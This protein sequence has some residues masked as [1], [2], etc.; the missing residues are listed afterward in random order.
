MRRHARQIRR[1]GMQPLM[2]INSGDDLPEPASLVLARWLGQYRSEL[3]PLPVAGAVLGAA[4]WLHTTHARW[5]GLVLAV[6]VTAAIVIAV[7]GPKLGLPDP[8]ERLYGAATVLAAG[9]WTTAAT[10]VSPFSSPLPQALAAGSLVL[11]VPWWTNRRRRA[12]VRVERTL[13]A[14]PDIAR[15][16]GLAGTQVMSA[17]VDVWGWRARF[18]LARGQT[19]TDVTAKIPAIESGLGTVRGAVRVYP[20]PDN[21]AHRCE[22]RVFD[23]EPHAN[24]IPWPGPSV[25]SITQPVDFGPFEDAQPCRVLLLRRRVLIGG[26][27]GAGKSGWLNVL[28]GNLAACTDAVIWGIDLKGGMELDPWA[29]CIARLATTP[30]QATAL[31]ADAVTILHARAEHLAAQGLRT[32]EPTPAMPALVIVVDEYAELTEQAPGA[33]RH[34]DSVARLGRAL[35]VTMAIATQ[36]P[37]QKV[38]GQGAVRSQIDIRVCLRVSER[39]DVDLVL[40]QGMLAAGW[41][42]HTLDAPGKF[43]ISSPEHGTP[44]RARAYHITDD[45]VAQTAARYTGSRPR[46]DPVSRHAIQATRHD[47]P[48]PPDAEPPHPASRQADHGQP[49]STG[50]GQ[51]DPDAILRRELSAAPTGGVPVNHLITATGMSRRWVFYR[52]R[53]LEAE[54]SAIQITRGY[55]QASR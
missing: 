52:L 47:T 27:T 25:T 5:W 50:D 2:L 13:Q 1:S 46:L 12:K 43:L 36:R 26:T 44:K 22:I 18:R 29:S 51:P 38:M 33:A 39:R 17:A 19:I 28:M 34:A 41:H 4:W 11:A 37:T 15:A 14:W 23:I 54:G 3:V 35:A 6:T 49:G 20:T 42:A 55:W 8:L 10:I 7:L 24:A 45:A 48:A 9:A 40:S 21:L 53:R 16:V 32:W 30:D 31:L